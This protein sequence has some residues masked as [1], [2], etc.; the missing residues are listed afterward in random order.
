MLKIRPSSW[1]FV[2]ASFIMSAYGGA[3]RYAAVAPRIST[4][5]SL[6]WSGSYS[7]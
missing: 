6:I 4:S 2:F 7:S 5:A 1:N 3:D